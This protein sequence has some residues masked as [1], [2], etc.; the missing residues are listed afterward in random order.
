M[1]EDRTADCG[2]LALMPGPEPS[3]CFASV[4]NVA[5]TTAPLLSPFA[6]VVA[7]IPFFFKLTFP[8]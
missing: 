7:I 5:P 8:A 1:F 3:A 2:S 6:L 4:L